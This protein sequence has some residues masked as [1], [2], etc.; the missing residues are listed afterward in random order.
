MGLFIIRPV[1]T[2]E[3]GRAKHPGKCVGHS[4]ELLDIV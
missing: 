2:G 4:L 3:V 1:T